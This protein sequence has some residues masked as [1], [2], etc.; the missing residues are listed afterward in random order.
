MGYRSQVGYVVAFQDNEAGKEL[1]YTFLAEARIKEETAQ[2]FSQTWM[3]IQI[4]KDKLLVYLDK[5]DVKWYDDTPEVDC[6]EALIALAELYV[7]REDDRVRPINTA[8]R[9]AHEKQY[10]HIPWNELLAQHVQ[11]PTYIELNIGYSYVRLGE[12]STDVDCR[13]NGWDDVYNRV[14]HSSSIEFDID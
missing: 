4:N 8:T 14:F 7:N 11:Q 12:E 3:P 13:H 9:E 10:G 1:F 2:C 6:H 5:D